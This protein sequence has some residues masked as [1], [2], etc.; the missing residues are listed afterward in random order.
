MGKIASIIIIGLFAAVS[1]MLL[2]PANQF[3]YAA[4][5]D[6]SLATFVPPRH[7]INTTAQAWINEVEKRTNGR[8]KVTLYPAQSLLSAPKT[9]EGVFSGTA[10]MGTAAFTYNTGMFPLMMTL[11][12]AFGISSSDVGTKVA[13]A[14]F[15][16][17]QPEELKEIKV[18]YTYTCSPI[19]IAFKK[20]VR[21]L[22]ELKGKVIRTTGGQKPFIKA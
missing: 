16:K 1:A 10:D 20:P 9:Y 19:G 21:T 8:V 17:Y 4:E 2:T 13:N 7:N 6:L 15:E 18:L 3:C 14:L 12:S 22:S 11:D 5:Y